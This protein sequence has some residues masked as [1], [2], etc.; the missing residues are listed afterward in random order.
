MQSFWM[1]K[2]EPLY[3]PMLSSFGGGS[4]RGFRGLGKAKV[5]L[6]NLTSHTFTNAGA[7]GLTGP[8]LGQTQN[9]YSGATFFTAGSYFSVPDTGLQRWTVAADGKWRI[10]AAGAA[11]QYA[12]EGAIMQADFDLLAGDE[13]I[14]AVGQMGYEGSGQGGDGAG[15]TFV[16]KVVSSGGDS[17]ATVS[18]TSVTPLVIAGGGGNQKCGSPGSQ[19]YMKGNDGTSATSTANSNT[20]PVGEGGL[21]YGTGVYAGG[22]YNSG[23]NSNAMRSFLQNPYGTSAPCGTSGSSRG[24]AYGGG[25]NFCAGGGGGYTGGAGGCTQNL[26]PDG[27]SASGGGSFIASVGT[28]VHTHTGSFTN[29]GTLSG[30]TAIATSTQYG[31]TSQN[32][33][34]GMGYVY[35]EYLG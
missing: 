19:T 11:A 8:N 13:L 25:A 16:T 31:T 18:N 7:T 30:H 12:G 29:S 3:A 22:G 28:N 35:V 24:G 10:R 1:P 20:P 32:G 15:G 6:Y 21:Y 34:T 14:M 2:K 26:S 33:N 9:A 17:L 5:V 23:G 4:T 27:N